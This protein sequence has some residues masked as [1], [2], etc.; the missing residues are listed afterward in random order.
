ML[1]K[2]IPI[3]KN[4]NKIEKMSVITLTDGGRT[5]GRLVSTMADDNK[6]T[7][8]GHGDTT[9]IKIGQKS[10]STVR[11]KV[12]LRKKLVRVHRVHY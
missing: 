8:A 10:Y 11:V 3:F 2:M 6:A 7:L 1:I 5:I 9:V 12:L 4:K